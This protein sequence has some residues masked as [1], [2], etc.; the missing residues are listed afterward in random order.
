MKPWICCGHDIGELCV[1]AGCGIPGR[2]FFC[3]EPRKDV[4]LDIRP[5]D[6]LAGELSA[7]WAGKI[8]KN[9]WDPKQGGLF[10]CDQFG[11]ADTEAWRAVAL[12]VRDLI[13]SSVKI[14]DPD[15]QSTRDDLIAA[16]QSYAE[17]WKA[18]RSTIHSEAKTALCIA[19]DRHEFEVWDRSRIKLASEIQDDARARRSGS[20]GVS[21]PG[22]G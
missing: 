22:K 19:L 20:P 11:R 18:G 5:E 4:Q 12:R 16:I 8:A 2:C 1:R 15:S 3:G 6:W 13:V 7:L 21:G 10:S 17:E 14:A 9:Y